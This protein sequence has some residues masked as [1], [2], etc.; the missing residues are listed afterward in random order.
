MNLQPATLSSFVQPHPGMY[1]PPV[2]T[3]PLRPGRVPEVAE[4]VDDRLEVPIHELTFA[5]LR[6]TDEVGRIVHLRQQLQ[7]PAAT[8]ADPAFHT[9]EKKETKLGL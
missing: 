1:G 3:P 4:R 9:R 5:H 2:S 7:L 6:T 8:L